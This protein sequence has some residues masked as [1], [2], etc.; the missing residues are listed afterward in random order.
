MEASEASN[1]QTRGGGELVCVFGVGQGVDSSRWATS[2]G[3]EPPLARCELPCS[4]GFDA[5]KKA[6]CGG[7]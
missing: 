3:L 1:L 6:G 7:V 4:D 2:G 5:Q